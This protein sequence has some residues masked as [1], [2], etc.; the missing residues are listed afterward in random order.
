MLDLKEKSILEVSKISIK[1]YKINLFIT[2]QN[3]DKFD[4]YVP[5][6]AKL[7]GI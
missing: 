2:R 6:T 7:K 5:D 4:Y 1:C 3:N